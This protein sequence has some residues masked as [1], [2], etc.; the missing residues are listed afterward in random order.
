M[1]DKG[2]DFLDKFVY[3]LESLGKEMVWFRYREGKIIRVL[4]IYF[5]RWIGWVVN[6]RL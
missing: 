2:E 3:D 5:G 4:N 6:L 1:V